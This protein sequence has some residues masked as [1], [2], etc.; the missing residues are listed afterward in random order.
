MPQL[1][2]R[3]LP[4]SWPYLCV[5]SIQGGGLHHSQ[6]LASSTML[7]FGAWFLI[8]EMVFAIHVLKHSPCPRK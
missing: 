8:C 2:G 6:R 4:W 5:E 1:V 3:T 7:S